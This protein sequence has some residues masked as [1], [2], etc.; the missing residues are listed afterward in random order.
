VKITKIKLICPKCNKLIVEISET[1][2]GMTIKCE[3]CGAY[4]KYDA[5]RKVAIQ[6]PKPSR[7][8]SSG[9]RFY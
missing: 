1:I 6:V 8:S 4:A 3:K 9:T 2:A 7:T 5:S